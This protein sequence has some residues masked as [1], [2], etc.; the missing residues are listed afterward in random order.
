MINIEEEVIKI[1]YK[2]WNGVLNKNKMYLSSKLI[3]QTNT[4]INSDLKKWKLLFNN[5]KISLDIKTK[6]I[7]LPNNIKFEEFCYILR[8]IIDGIVLLKGYCPMHAAAME[9]DNLQIIL[10]A[11]TNNGKSYLINKLYHSLNKSNIIG[12]DHLIFNGKQLFGNS[13]LRK[14]EENKS[15]YI[16][17]NN[18]YSSCLK[19]LVVGIKISTINSSYKI[20]EKKEILKKLTELE[21]NKY[22]LTPFT[23]REEIYSSNQIFKTELDKLYIEIISNFCKELY[24]ISGSLEYIEHELIEI[25]KNYRRNND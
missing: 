22:I 25:I 14:R 19:K 8:V 23:I 5:K 7:N 13:V 10:T 18:I 24:F 2:K 6:T 3:T 4:I 17:L 21:F 16:A 11:K 1:P 12:H 9:Y 15:K 20:Q